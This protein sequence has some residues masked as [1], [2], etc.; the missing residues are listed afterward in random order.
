VYTSS[1]SVVFNG[2][3]LLDGDESLPYPKSF[4]DFYTYTKAE[5][6]KLVLAANGEDGLAT[7]AIRPHSIFGPGDQHFWPKVIANAEAGKLRFYMG[8][9]ENLSDFTFVD[10]CVLGHTLAAEVCSLSYSFFFFRTR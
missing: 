2:V 8:D 1:A 7:V 10:N 6:E 4:L 5:A 3:D 9:G